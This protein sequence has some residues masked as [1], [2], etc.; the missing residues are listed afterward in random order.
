MKGDKNMLYFYC[1]EVT[2]P[3]GSVRKMDGVA[4]ANDNDAM[5]ILECQQVVKK[6]LSAKLSEVEPDQGW[7]DAS[8]VFT[9]FNPL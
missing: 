2:N 6:L 9:A 3:K 4:M 7:N 8:H 5:S 1:C